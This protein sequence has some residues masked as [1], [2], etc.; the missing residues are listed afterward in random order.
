M[1]LTNIRQALVESYV[2]GNF[3]LPT[4]YP[5]TT[6]NPTSDVAWAQLDIIPNQPSVAA[7]GENGTDEHDGIMQIAL[8]YPLNEGDGDVVAMADTIRT[9]YKAGFSKTANEQSVVVRSCGRSAG[10][11]VDGWFRVVITINWYAHTAR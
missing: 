6:F 4:A 5:N 1:S 2:D 9:Q 10:G 8:N 7:L 3:G 11:E